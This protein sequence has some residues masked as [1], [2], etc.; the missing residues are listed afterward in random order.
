MSEY[1]PNKTKRSNIHRLLPMLYV[2]AEWLTGQP[3]MMVQRPISEL[4]GVE[5][6][7]IRK[8]NR[9]RSGLRSALVSMKPAL[10]ELAVETR[11]IGDSEGVLYECIELRGFPPLKSSERVFFLL[12][13]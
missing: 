1:N 2:F 6:E 3:Q 8:E 4:G 12:P 5:L 7:L 11:K 9:L 13:R 10:Q